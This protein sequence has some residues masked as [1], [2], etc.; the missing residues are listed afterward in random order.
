MKKINGIY[1]SLCSLTLIC[2]PVLFAGSMGP[3][4]VGHTP[5]YFELIGAGSVSAVIAGNG[6]LG[7]TG[8]EVDT[9]I[10]TNRNDWNSW[11][12]Q[13]GAGYVYFISNAQKY[14][15]KVQ[16]FPRIEPEL[17]VYYTSYKNSGDVFRFGSSAFNSLTYTIPVDS[18]RLMVDGALTVASWRQ[19]STYII[20]GIGN[21]WNRIGYRDEVAVSTPC[22][23]ANLK[24]NN[25]NSS[26]FVWEAG[27]GLTYDINK[28]IALSFEYLY[29]DFGTLKTS[30]NGTA[31]GI[32]TPL[33]SPASFNFAAQGLL[34]G[35]HIVV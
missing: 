14:S 27:A 6:L 7:V 4:G 20:G 31:Y 32:T 28:N 3:I 2:S 8:N 24:L 35:L 1:L 19:I 11:G 21:A 18:T 15:D 12:G 30:G 23:I 25:N 29:T 33:I 9:L 34:L 16:W 5:G 26:N 17:N 10:Q 13:L 22:N